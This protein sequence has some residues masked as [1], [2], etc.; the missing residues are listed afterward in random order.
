M[1]LE[2]TKK[3][4]NKERV[5]ALMKEC[6]TNRREWIINTEPTMTDLLEEFPCMKD[7]TMVPH[8]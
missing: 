8:F 6:C 2:V 3:N 1:K 4:R 7:H 5:M